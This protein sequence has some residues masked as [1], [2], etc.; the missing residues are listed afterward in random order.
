M[1]FLPRSSQDVSLGNCRLTL[2]LPLPI[3]INCQIYYCH[4]SLRFSPP[5]E[6]SSTDRF[7]KLS[8]D[9]LHGIIHNRPFKDIVNVS[10]ATKAF[11]QV[12]V[13][14]LCKVV[15]E[16]M[17]WLK[18]ALDQPKVKATGSRCYR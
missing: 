10:M 12:P 7:V 4:H 13:N 17:L 15:L 6:S 14:M 8:T 1:A 9:V 3:L 5:V 16:D 18:G 2:Y 11:R